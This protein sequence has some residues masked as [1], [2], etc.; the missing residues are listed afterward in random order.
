MGPHQHSKFIVEQMS[1]YLCV[2]KRLFVRRQAAAGLSWW[3]KE[4]LQ[5]A[6]AAYYQ[7]V[8]AIAAERKAAAF[9]LNQV[10][11]LL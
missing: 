8:A 3:Q 11:I 2:A 6:A 7:Q 4:V 1:S 10:G 5:E 9:A